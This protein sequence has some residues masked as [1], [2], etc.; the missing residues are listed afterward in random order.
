M[1]P[2]KKLYYRKY[3]LSNGLDKFIKYVWVMRSQEMQSAKD[4]L[5]PD[6]YPEII[7][8]QKGGYRKE[9]ISDKN[10]VYI[11]DKS[12]IIGMQTQSVLASRINQCQLIGLKLHPLGAYTLFGNLLKDILDVNCPLDKF[13]VDWLSDLDQKLQGLKE[14]T[15]IVALLSETLSNHKKDFKNK[16]RIELAATYLKTILSVKGQISIKDLAKKHFVSVRQF[17]RNF[18]D[19]FGISPKKFINIIR[20]KHL[21]KSSILKQHPPINFLDYGYYDQMHFIK[22]FQKHLGINPS[23]SSNPLFLQM[24]KMAQLNA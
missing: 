12:C 10:N 15:T 1:L 11:V 9:F 14:D 2:L 6:G 5:I 23:K 8:V 17:Q 21:Y 24:N 22:D 20:F 3:H 7:F 19:F 16:L 4:L 18:K 13:G